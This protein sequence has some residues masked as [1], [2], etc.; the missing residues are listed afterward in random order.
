MESERAFSMRPGRI[1]CRLAHLQDRV[2]ARQHAA[3]ALVLRG[4]IKRDRM[5]FIAEYKRAS[6]SQGT[7]TERSPS[8]VAQMYEHAWR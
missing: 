1:W 5:A 2:C 8:E 7:L 4:A 3:V 6:P